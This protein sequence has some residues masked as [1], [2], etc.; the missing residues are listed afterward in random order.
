M[1]QT[2]IIENIFVALRTPLFKVNWLFL[3]NFIIG[4]KNFIIKTFLLVSKIK[5]VNLFAK[6]PKHTK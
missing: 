3:S 5:S 1:M 2:H 4:I 6:L